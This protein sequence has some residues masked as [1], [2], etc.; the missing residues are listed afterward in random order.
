MSHVDTRKGSDEDEVAMIANVVDAGSCRS[1]KKMRRARKCQWKKL[2]RGIGIEKVD[3]CPVTDENVGVKLKFQ[4]AD[5]HKPLIA[6]R[7]LVEKGN[8]VV[9]GPEPG[10]NHIENVVR[11]ESHDEEKGIRIV[12]A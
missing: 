11:E 7:R 3:L 5:V 12:Y 10:E 4:V 2:E 9:F 6:V 8:R 1:A